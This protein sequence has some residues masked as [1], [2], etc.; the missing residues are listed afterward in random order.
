[1]EAAEA[2]RLR[3]RERLEATLAGLAELQFLRRRQELRVKRLLAASPAAAAAFAGSCSAE[4]PPGEGAAAAAPRSLEEKFLEDNI[5]LLRRQLFWGL[6]SHGG[7]PK[8]KNMG[9]VFVPGALAA[10]NYVLRNVVDIHVNVLEWWEFWMKARKSLND[11]WLGKG[12][13]SHARFSLCCLAV[14]FLHAR[15]GP[16][17]PCKKPSC[18]VESKGKHFPT[19]GQKLRNAAGYQKRCLA[20]ESSQNI[21]PRAFDAHLLLLAHCVLGNCLRRRDAGLLN[22]LQELDKQI[23]DLRLD[24]EKTAEEHL[25]TD[26]RPSSGFYE[27]SDG[28]S[29]SLSNSSNSVFSECLSTCHSSTCFCGPLDTSLSGSDGRPKSAGTAR[30]RKALELP[31]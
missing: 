16:L 1:G 25:E 22:Q 9:S 7:K 18:A 12:G 23:S 31:S 8:I 20:P 21:W 29:G 6:H 30:V 14:R 17:F 2:E 5:L 27:L 13:R 26:S 4:A 10:C 3:T 28:A 24:V 11:Q 15:N 19:T